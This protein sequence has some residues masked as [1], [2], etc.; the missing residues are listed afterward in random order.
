MLILQNTNAGHVAKAATSTRSREAKRRIGW[1]CRT[2]KLTFC[3]C[4]LAGSAPLGDVYDALISC[5][6]LASKVGASDT[7]DR[8]IAVKEG[9]SF[10]SLAVTSLLHAAAAAAHDLSSS[11][12][13]RRWPLESK[14]ARSCARW[15]GGMRGGGER[16]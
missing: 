9:S 6:T 12:M 3:F 10:A 1:Q 2:Y 15:S 14:A 16:L 7:T 13:E 4:S 8:D 5:G 11:Q